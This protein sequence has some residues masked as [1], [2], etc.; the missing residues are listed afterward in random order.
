MLGELALEGM[1]RQARA[2]RL[3]RPAAVAHC[4]RLIVEMPGNSLSSV[5]LPWHQATALVALRTNLTLIMP[6]LGLKHLV[7]HRARPSFRVL[8]QT[9]PL[10]KSLET[11]S[12]ESISRA[13]A[14]SFPMLHLAGLEH[15]RSVDLTKLTPGSIQLP[16]SCMLHVT[17]SG[18]A[19]P[20]HGT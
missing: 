18:N 13:E 1:L 15:L 3:T 11:L 12:L 17:S 14:V 7:V 4:L 19:L 9:L 6:V 10:F 20:A 8:S 16:T 5:Y 2:L